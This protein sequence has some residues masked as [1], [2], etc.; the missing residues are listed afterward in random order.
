MGVSSL[1]LFP[2]IVPLAQVSLTIGGQPATLLYAG[3]APFMV[4]GVIQINAVVPEGIGSGPQPVV[5]TV[6]RNSNVL[7]RVS[8]A[9]Q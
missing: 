5:L 4:L 7:Q 2:P 1:A 8:V 9:V 3:P 6:G